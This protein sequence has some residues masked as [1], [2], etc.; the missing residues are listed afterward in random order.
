[1]YTIVRTSRALPSRC[2]NVR[3][4]SASVDLSIPL[5]DIARRKVKASGEF[6]RML[7]DR[8]LHDAIET[9]RYTC[10]H[11]QCVLMS[12]EFVCVLRP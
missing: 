8:P 1:M 3:H 6:Q 2:S 9:M 11:A 10:K 4:L 12:H 5:I 7:R